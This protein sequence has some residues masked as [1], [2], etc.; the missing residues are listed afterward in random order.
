M[1]ED[2][3]HRELLEQSSTLALITRGRRS[4]RPHRVLLWFAYREGT[5]YLMAHARTHGQGTDWYRNARA[6]P[7]VTVEADGCRWIGRAEPL[8]EAMLPTVMQWFAEK[9]G[10]AAVRAWYEGTP[11]L[12][13][14]I[15][16]DR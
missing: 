16:F 14:R 5:V 9:Y 3:Q 7:T 2:E 4:G 15:T 11:R 12:P 6:H 8:P 13:L 10:S 1:T